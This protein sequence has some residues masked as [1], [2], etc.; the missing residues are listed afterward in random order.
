MFHVLAL[1]LAARPDSAPPLQRIAVSPQ[2]IVL[3]LALC[4]VALGFL[5]FSTFR[6]VEIGRLGG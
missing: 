1:A 5:P 2:V 6:L 4:S 3:A